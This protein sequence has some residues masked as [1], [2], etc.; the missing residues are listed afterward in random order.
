[1]ILSIMFCNL[2]VFKTYFLHLTYD[3]FEK[4]DVAVEIFA[5]QLVDNSC[6]K[7]RFQVRYTHDGANI[8]VNRST[9]Y[10]LDCVFMQML[11]IVIAHSIVLLIGNVAQVWT[12]ENGLYSF[13]LIFFCV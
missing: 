12:I 8:A 10:Y 7:V 5:V 4:L 1:M 3:S 13:R 6:S 11:D 9:R 2:N